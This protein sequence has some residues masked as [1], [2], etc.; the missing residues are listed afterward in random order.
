MDRA[1]WKLERFQDFL[2]ARRQLLSDTV[3]NLIE[4][5]A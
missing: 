2:A 1:L 3:N 4:S 5:P